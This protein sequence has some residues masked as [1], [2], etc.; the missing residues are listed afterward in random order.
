MPRALVISALSA[1]T[2]SGLR[3]RYL[4]SALERLGWEA[5]FTA[6]EGAP[7]PYSAEI[8]SSAP[9]LMARGFGRFDLA[10]GV[11]PYPNAWLA[12]GLARLRGAVSV[13]DVDDDDGGYRGGALGLLTRLIQAPGFGVSPLL[14]THHPLLREKLA[15]AHGA[16]RVLDL[17][18]GVDTKVFAA[19]KKRRPR[20]AGLEKASPLLAFTAHLNI[21]CQLDVLLEALG[22][23]L[24]AHAKA[25]LAIA[26]DGPDAE[27]FRAL[28]APFGPQ[29]RFLGKVDPHGAAALL[30]CADA[31]L[32]AYGP[33]EGN[34]Y[35]VPMKVAES[36]AVGVPVVTNLV[37]GLQALAPYLYESSLDPR[38][39]GRALDRALRAR[40]GRT[41]RGRRQVRTH[42]DW[43][44]VAS[45]FLAQVRRR[46]PSLPRGAREPA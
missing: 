43:D 34:R 33:G 2:G 31:S 12:L 36:L 9:S 11:K 46:V 45:A 28:A 35:R 41:L 37:P 8:L 39:F 19:R 24:R 5:V 16:D 27:R 40:D 14:S 7:Q 10:V 13:L 22:P 1:R 32:S 38:D 26:G 29:V 23:W 25:V 18:Q 17:P 3:A 44:R 42:L 6:P 4:A 21:A 15:A 20:L 30:A